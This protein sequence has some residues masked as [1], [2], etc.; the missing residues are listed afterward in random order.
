M[1]PTRRKGG[2]LSASDRS[3]VAK[4]VAA[5]QPHR[6]KQDRG[7]R[8]LLP[9][10]KRLL[11][12]RGSDRKAHAVFGGVDACR[13]ARLCSRLPRAMFRVTRNS[14]RPVGTRVR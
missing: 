12:T 5:H 2:D 10:R 14:T 13:S 1:A 8:T 7:C 11:M 4:A 9:R 3:Y 6:P